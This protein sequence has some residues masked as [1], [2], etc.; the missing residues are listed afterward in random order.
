[1]HHAH[2]HACMSDDF[3]ASASSDGVS[4]IKVIPV[5]PYLIDID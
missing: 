3:E 2:I 1:M 5:E 4:N